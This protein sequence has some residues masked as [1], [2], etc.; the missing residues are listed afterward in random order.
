M[1]IFFALLISSFTTIAQAA[2]MD[3]QGR[4]RGTTNDGTKV[5]F[6]YYSDFNGCSEKSN[7]GIVWSRGGELLTGKRTFTETK[8]IYTFKSARIEFKN[9]TGNTGGTLYVGKDKIKLAC[10]IRDYEYGEC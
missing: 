6:K 7:A 3:F 1:K 9:S 8:D 5:S 4:C 2:N 10:E